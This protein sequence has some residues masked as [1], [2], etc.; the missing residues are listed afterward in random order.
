MP[1]GT[2]EVFT[3]PNCGNKQPLNKS[4]HRSVNCIACGTSFAIVQDNEGG[5]ALVPY[6]NQE[7]KSSKQA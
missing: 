3:C 4:A 1:R 2:G 5:K 7:S 6:Y